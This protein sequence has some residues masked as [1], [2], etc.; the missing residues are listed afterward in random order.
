M[1]DLNFQMGERE[2]ERERVVFGLEYVASCMEFVS[3]EFERRTR[4]RGRPRVPNIRKLHE[5]STGG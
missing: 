4:T 3:A 1:D 2:I 5:L